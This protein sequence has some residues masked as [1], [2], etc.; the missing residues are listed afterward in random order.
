MNKPYRALV[1][2]GGFSLFS[3]IM[4]MEIHKHNNTN[5]CTAAPT[6]TI[7]REEDLRRHHQSY[8]GWNGGEKIWRSACGCLL[9][10]R[11][12]H[13]R[14]IHFLF[15]V[16]VSNYVHWLIRQKNQTT[17]QYHLDLL[18]TPFSNLP[19]IFYNHDHRS[20]GNHEGERSNLQLTF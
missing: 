15:Q 10:S 3:R 18:R 4:D 12:L 2:G 1:S 13:L 5:H 8:S 14:I 17:D 7:Q 20:E 19:A 16:I 11:K 6:T 9:N